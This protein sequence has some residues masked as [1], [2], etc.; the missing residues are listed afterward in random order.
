[1]GLATVLSRFCFF[2]ICVESSWNIQFASLKCCWADGCTTA[3]KM[4]LR[5]TSWLIL[6]LWFTKTIGLL[7][8]TQIAPHTI[9]DTGFRSCLVMSDV[10]RSSVD[11]LLSFWWLYACF[12]VHS[13][14]S[15]KKIPTEFK[16]ACQWSRRW[17]DEFF[18]AGTAEV[19]DSLWQFLELIGRWFPS[20]EQY[21]LVV[22]HFSRHQYTPS[23]NFSHLTIYRMFLYYTICL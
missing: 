22:I 14:S 10:P 13:F 15:M 18:E 11:Q 3:S 20:H 1:M 4:L 21:C 2:W 9:T 8:L 6:S 17:E 19:W 16:G 23:L 12:I 5:Y 7:P